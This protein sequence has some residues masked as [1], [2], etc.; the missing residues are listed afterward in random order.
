MMDAKSHLS[1]RR[2][3]AIL[4]SL[5]AAPVVLRSEP[6]RKP[7]TFD[8]QGIVLGA[9]A[10]LRLQHYDARAA[11]GALERCL[12]EVARLESIF[13][14]HREDSA[15]VRLNA[16]G[17]LEAAPSDLRAV[18]GEAMALAALSD[19]AF[20]P[21]V[22]PL[23]ELFASHFARSGASPDGPDPQSIAAAR[24]LVD[25]RQIDIDGASIRLLQPGMAITLNGIAQGYIT[26][27]V[28]ALLREEGFRHVLVSMGESL[29]LGPKW[30]GRAWRVAIADPSA[31]QSIL[32][33][34]PLSGGAVATSGGYGLAFDPS[35]RF[36]HIINP[37]TGRATSGWASVTVLA[38]RAML[39]DGLST[40]LCAAPAGSAAAVLGGR[41]KAFVV[42][43][44]AGS[45][46]W[47]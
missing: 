45:P 21:T 27:R 47:I 17:R 40:A 19:G 10:E 32:T 36:T 28:G 9:H 25:W 31:P 29:A 4:A 6:A 30:D 44:G 34:L 15:L 38:D 26:D 42:P 11:A 39:A 43:M 41:G 46:H 1:R 16:T 20:D 14:L 12:A 33:E 3:V 18:L 35:R 2:F 24:R 7:Q 5:A 23:W 22:Q 8:W 37:R 13:S